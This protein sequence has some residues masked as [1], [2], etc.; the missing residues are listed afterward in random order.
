MPYQVKGKCV[1]KKDG[2]AKVGCTK[3][4]VNKYLGALHANANENELIGGKA[5]DLTVSDIAKKFKVS[6]E[7][8]NAQIK[9][10]IT[11]ELEH[12]D[13]KEKAIEIAMD[14]LSEIPDYYDRLEKME[15]NAFNELKTKEVYENTKTLIKRLIRE[16]LMGK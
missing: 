4:D 12:T 16:N 15:N 10:G 6:V 8:I 2:G 14:H 3:G 13:N 9:K 5:D 1:Y 11:F 7:D